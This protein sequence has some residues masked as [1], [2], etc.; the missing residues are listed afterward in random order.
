MA[1]EDFLDRYT[2]EVPMFTSGNSICGPGFADFEYLRWAKEILKEG[3][4]KS[5]RTGVTTLDY[6]GSP[7][8]VFEIPILSISKTITFQSG[9]SGL[10]TMEIW[11]QYTDTNGDHGRPEMAKQLIRL[12]I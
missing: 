5:N 12:P 10:M 9:T 11:V 7:Q 6:F 3:T 4:L 8:M 1:K 2:N